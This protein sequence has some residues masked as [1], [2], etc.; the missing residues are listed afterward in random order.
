MPSTSF[1]ASLIW[2]PRVNIRFRSSP[3]SLIAMLACV[4]LSMASMRWLMGWPISILAPV[5]TESL[6]RT[7]SN[8]SLCERS[9]S[10]KGA[11]S[12]DTFT[13]KACS[14]SSARPVFRA[15][16]CI[17]GMESR[18]SSACRPILSDSSSE[19]P[20]KEL[21]FIVNEP[22]LN[23]GKKL[24]PN[25]KK[26]PNATRKRASVLPTTVR[27]CANAHSNPFS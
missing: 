6:W 5:M 20:G 7:S 27:L 21:T 9:L 10:S 16:V 26:H 15:T 4:P 12:S 11:S 24:C 8:S 2:F 23:A 14:S 18:I 25:V 17:S 19:M 3:K 13:P 1:T 22:S